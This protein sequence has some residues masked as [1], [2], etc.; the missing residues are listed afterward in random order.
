M[1]MERSATDL[2]MLFVFV[3]FVG[4]MAGLTGYA[5]VKGDSA[6]LFYPIVSI[7]NANGAELQICGADGDL[8]GYPNLYITDLAP[9]LDP[10]LTDL[11]NT[12]VCVKKCPVPSKGQNLECA[13]SQQGIC[14]QIGESD[15]Y[16]TID[17]LNYCVPSHFDDLPIAY[18]TGWN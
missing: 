3:V 9:K 12:G 13:P 14:D 6:R 4:S 17:I 11:F 10:S 18:Q 1:V 2:L 8:V 15:K 7:H 16:D 5:F